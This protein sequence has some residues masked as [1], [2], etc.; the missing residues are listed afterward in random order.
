MLGTNW[1]LSLSLSFWI[2]EKPFVF[3]QL[4]Y[5]WV[6]IS[7]LRS[8]LVPSFHLLLN[9]T[10][11]FI[12]HRIIQIKSTLKSYLLP[13]KF[14]P[15]LLRLRK[16]LPLH[17]AFVSCCFILLFPFKSVP[18][19]WRN[20]TEIQVKTVIGNWLICFKFQKTFFKIKFQTQSTSS[21]F[22]TASMC[23][24]LQD[25]TSST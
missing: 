13:D 15:V 8:F 21:F 4:W 16:M 23:F 18:A 25:H 2:S 12:I 24:F 19:H 6:N 17:P 14:W 5:F 20:P 1:H 22:L 9:L 11:I 3:F 7:D 10:E